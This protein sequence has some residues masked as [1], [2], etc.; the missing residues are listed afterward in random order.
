MQSADALAKEKELEAFMIRYEEMTVEKERLENDAVIA[1]QKAEI[2]AEQQDTK[3]EDI[4]HNDKNIEQIQA[5]SRLHRVYSG[6]LEEVDGINLF[7]AHLPP[8]EIHALLENGAGSDNSL[9][10][11]FQNLTNVGLI[12]I[13]RFIKNA[14][15]REPPSA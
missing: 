7:G 1:K 2:F 3:I 11:S 8:Q 9:W 4:A 5:K 12:Q 6:G 13:R 10:E 14:A 15:R